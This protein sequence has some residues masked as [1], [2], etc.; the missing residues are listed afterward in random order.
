MHLEA[1]FLYPDR[2]LP[3]GTAQARLKVCMQESTPPT[4]TSGG[5]AARPVTCCTG[6]DTASSGR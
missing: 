2:Q 1:T 3:L 5:S 6:A 4:V